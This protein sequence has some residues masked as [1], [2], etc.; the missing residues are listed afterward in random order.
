MGCVFITGVGVSG[1]IPETDV[2][3]YFFF[4]SHAVFVWK[5]LDICKSRQN[6]KHFLHLLGRQTSKLSNHG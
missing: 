6:Y 3:Y 2:D 1:A 5:T 4:K